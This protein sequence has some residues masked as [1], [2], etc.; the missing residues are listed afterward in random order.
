VLS[1]TIKS[2]SHYPP[3]EAVWLFPHEALRLMVRRFHAAV[4]SSSFEGHVPW[5]VERVFEYFDLITRCLHAH[6]D[7][8]EL[9]VHRRGAVSQREVLAQCLE[10][11]ACYRSRLLSAAGRPSQTSLLVAPL[12]A[13]AKALRGALDE[14]LDEMEQ[15][16]EFTVLPSATSDLVEGALH[17]LIRTLETHPDAEMGAFFL[18]ASLVACEDKEHGWGSPQ[19]AA[20]FRESLSLRGRL[21]TVPLAMRTVYRRHLASLK[22]IALPSEPRRPAISLPR[23]AAVPRLVTVLGVPVGFPAG[24]PVT[25]VPQSTDFSWTP[26]I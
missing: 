9:I 18:C 17:A 16:V 24:S 11:I 6:W 20:F 19:N 5:K 3:S 25:G 10:V 13:H 15:F 26:D 22:E 12:R 23:L 2:R 8:E 4:R 7:H 21:L 1:G 14:Y